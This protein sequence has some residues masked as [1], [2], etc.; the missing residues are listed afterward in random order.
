MGQ[1]F[2]FPR[3]CNQ[4]AEGFPGVGGPLS[5]LAPSHGDAQDV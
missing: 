5:R 1:E 4:K 3:G 2:S